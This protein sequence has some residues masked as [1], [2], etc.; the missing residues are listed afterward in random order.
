MQGVGHSLFE[1][2]RRRAWSSSNVRE[3]DFLQPKSGDDI[4]DGG[5]E[6]MGAAHGI[7]RMSCRGR[8]LGYILSLA[9]Q[10]PEFDNAVLSD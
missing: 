1:F 2:I 6:P 9:Q 3:R 4:V 10:V 7:Q 5:H 8:W